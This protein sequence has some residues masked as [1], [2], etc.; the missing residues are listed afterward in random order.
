MFFYYKYVMANI[1]LVLL[2]IT[3]KKLH[4]IEEEAY[5]LMENLAVNTIQ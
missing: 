4:S 3:D 1:Y 2:S 5:K